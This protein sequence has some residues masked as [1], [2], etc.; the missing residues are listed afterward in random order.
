[1]TKRVLQNIEKCTVIKKTLLFSPF[2]IPTKYEISPWTKNEKRMDK[3]LDGAKKNTNFT[4]YQNKHV[5][6]N[7]LLVPEICKSS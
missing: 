4:A 3:M 2:I 5:S 6:D 1:M 7:N